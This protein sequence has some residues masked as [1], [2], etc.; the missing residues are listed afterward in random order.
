MVNVNASIR[1]DF[2]SGPIRELKWC[3]GAPTEL[4]FVRTALYDVRKAEHA[5]ISPN[6]GLVNARSRTRH[7]MPC[8]NVIGGIEVAVFDA[9]AERVVAK[10]GSGVNELRSI[11][12][13]YRETQARAERSALATVIEVVGSA[14][15]RPGARMIVTERGQ[16]KGTISG[17]CLES[18]L[19]QRAPEIIESGASRLI[20][21]DTTS[22]ED[23]VWGLGL[24]CN[25]VVRILFEPLLEGSEALRGLAFME[26]ILSA[27]KDGVVVTMVRDPRSGNGLGKRFLVDE[28]SGWQDLVCHGLVEAIQRDARKALQSGRATFCSYESSFGQTQIFHDVILPSRGLFI[29][30]ASDDVLPLVHLAHTVGWHVT[31]VDT[32]AR[33]STLERFRDADAV[34]LCRASDVG[35]QVSIQPGAAAVLM[36]HNY[37]DDLELLRTLLPAAIRYLGVMG[38]R[39][40]TDQLLEEVAN[41]LE[42]VAGALDRL[43]SPIGI[44]IGAETPQEIALAILAEIQAVAAERVGGLLRGPAARIHEERMRVDIVGLP[45][46]SPPKAKERSAGAWQ[47]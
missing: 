17:G 22:N 33:P 38:P 15:R 37:L 8:R 32:R 47:S 7:G 21:Y 11:L 41:G 45:V 20:E 12:E 18:D 24:G 30:G 16:T 39:K 46:P 23:I 6:S 9:S 44:D 29:F 27:R 2:C 5:E 42:P 43:Y 19:I 1:N 14:Y 36:T 26:D 35:T 10:G 28:P 3:E 31:V 4:D 34:W 40:R 13:T 25:G